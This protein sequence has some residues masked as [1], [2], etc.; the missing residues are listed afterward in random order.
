MKREPFAL[1]FGLTMLL[2]SGCNDPASDPTEFEPAPV[3]RV[4]TN[5]RLSERPTRGAARDSAPRPAGDLPVGVYFSDVWGTLASNKSNPRSIAEYCAQFIDG[6]KATLDVAGFEINNEVIIN[7]IL[8]AHR[9]GVRVRI[10]TDSDY[11]DDAGPK[12]FQ[13]VGIPVLPDNRNALM[14]NKFIVVD[15]QAVWTGSFNLTENCAY[16]NNNN[17]ITLF[18]AKVAADYSEKFR[19][20]WE[21]KKFGG[22]PSPSMKIPYPQTSLDDGTP[23]EVYF[24]THDGVDKHVIA[25]IRKARRSIQ[26]LAFSF[27]HKQIADAVLERADR[28][29]RVAGVVETR[30]ISKSSEYDRLSRHQNCDVLMDGN[31]FNMHHK[32]FIIDD[33]VLITGSFNFSSSATHDNDENLVIL[34]HARVAQKFQEEF[35]RVYRQ[36]SRSSAQGPGALRR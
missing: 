2:T 29:V 32:V 22:R 18:S 4:S 25:E 7:A 10:V 15:N 31:K 20:F 19:W 12:A 34:R 35:A 21:Y 8:D 1:L 23:I 5:D 27:T 26:F 24:S 9:R 11:L 17:G 30:Q 14:H 16:K 36:A 6:A 3:T 33:E 13:R 28:G